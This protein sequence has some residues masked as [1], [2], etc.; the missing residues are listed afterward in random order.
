MHKKYQ[1]QSWSSFMVC[2][3]CA[4]LWF[5]KLNPNFGM[6]MCLS[7]WRWDDRLEASISGSQAYTVSLA[8]TLKTMNCGV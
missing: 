4:D 5:W 6:T 7:Y 2:T 1:Q 3:K 8:Q